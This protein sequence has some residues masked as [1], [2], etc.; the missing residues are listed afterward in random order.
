MTPLQ[1]DGSLPDGTAWRIRR[2]AEWNGVLINDLD[3]RAKCDEPRY[4]LLNSHGFATSGTERPDWRNH[5]YDN[6]LERANQVAVI[7]LFKTQVDTP[8]TVIQYGHSG[9]GLIAEAMAEF[10]SE[11]IDGAVVGAAH[12][13]IALVEQYLD[14]VFLLKTLL[15]PNSDL[16]LVGIPEDA[17]T[18][19]SRWEHLV[20]KAQETE[21]GQ[22][23]IALSTAIAQFPSWGAPGTP[24][25]D[26]D[27][28]RAVQKAM[29]ETVRF[30]I[31]FT[32]RTRYM[33]EH[34]AGGNPASNVNVDY[35]SF[36]RN[37]EQAQ[38]RVVQNLYNAAGM[39]LSDDLARLRGAPRIAAHQEAVAFYA[40]PGRTPS[41]KIQVPVLRVHETGDAHVPPTVVE[42][43][44]NQ[45]R[46]QGKEEIYREIMLNRAG[47][48]TPSSTEMLVAVSTLHRRL[49][50]GEWGSTEPDALR[51]EADA[52]LPGQATF[53]A[54]HPP[55]A[56]R[57]F[58][59]E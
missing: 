2:P 32:V 56:N 19:V 43:Y 34:Y 47:H 36:L 22:A 7:E 59:L 44:G 11:V 16:P 48:G 27:D 50:T 24:S 15:D 28:T 18:L 25:P 55:R 13:N 54:Y 46:V 42:S 20:D 41:G 5:R 39:T 58:Y 21:D 33:F 30:I 51:V 14:L 26:P 10:E 40:T 23:R 45:I 12:D 53:S 31:G 4:A 1:L 9:G 49:E 17:D 6:I 38:L 29:Y 57:S 35:A 8:S 3:Y 37:A 52:I